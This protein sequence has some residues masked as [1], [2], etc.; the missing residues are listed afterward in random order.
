M[1]K[2]KKKEYYIKNLKKNPKVKFFFS[3]SFF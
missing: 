3:K 2:N 1:K